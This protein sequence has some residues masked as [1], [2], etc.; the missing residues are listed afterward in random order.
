MLISRN[1]VNLT[2][3]IGGLVVVAVIGAVF[4]VFPTYRMLDGN[5]MRRPIWN[6]PQI[7][8]REALQGLTPDDVARAGQAPRQKAFVDKLRKPIIYQPRPCW[9][10]S[11]KLEPNKPARGRIYPTNSLL[12]VFLGSIAAYVLLLKRLGIL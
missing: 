2:I 12:Y 3:F 7:V 5:N 11:P 1:Q 10:G 9:L 6:P 4:A 8:I